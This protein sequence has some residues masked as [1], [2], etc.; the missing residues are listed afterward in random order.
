MLCGAYRHLDV[1]EKRQT[2]VAIRRWD[3]DLWCFD[4]TSAYTRDWKLGLRL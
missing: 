4:T 3:Y 2:R 1:V